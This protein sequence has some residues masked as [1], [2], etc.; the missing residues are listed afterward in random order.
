MEKVTKIPFEDYILKHQFATEDPEAV[1]FSSHPGKGPKNE[2]NYYNYDRTKDKFIP[3]P[4]FSGNKNLP[5]AGLNLTL[6]AYVEWTRRFDDGLL[7]SEATKKL[8]W[9]PFVFTN[10][11][12]EF[13]NGWDVYKVNGSDSFGFSG[14]GVS[15]YR[16]FL[17]QGFSIIVLTTGY[18][19]YAVQDLIIDQIAGMLDAGL[20]DKVTMLNEEITNEYLLSSDSVDVKKMVA[21]VKLKNPTANLEVIFNALGYRLFFD[22]D[23]KQEAIALF[24]S[25]VLKYP[26]SYDAYGS[27]GYLQLLTEQYEISR[28]N[29]VMAKELNPNNSYSDRRIKEIDAILIERR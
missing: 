1:Y 10:S 13:L 22:L 23:R 5:L 20:Q 14:G 11:E 25:N 26:E 24:E 27:L 29:Y 4:E 19:N 28:K 8:M 15:G 21:E 12:R 16:K 9:T 7:L 3:K 17:K 18:K 6:D 2:A